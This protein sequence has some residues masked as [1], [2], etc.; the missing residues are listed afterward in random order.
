MYIME[1]LE[2]VHGV[3]CQDYKQGD[4][5]TSG[6][7][8]P[9]RKFI[10]SAMCRP[11]AAKWSP[12]AKNT[13][14]ET[15]ILNRVDVSISLWDDVNKTQGAYVIPYI[16]HRIMQTR[17]ASGGDGLL[18]AV[19]PIDNENTRNPFKNI[20]LSKELYDTMKQ[21]IENSTATFVQKVQNGESVSAP[22]SQVALGSE[23]MKA[24]LKVQAEFAARR[25]AAPQA[26][27]K[28]A[29]TSVA[30]S[31]AAALDDEN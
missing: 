15:N 10:I 12:S 1:N 5:T 6:V 18:F 4:V 20:L 16:S 23:L 27:T 19:N 30:Q 7:I 11:G 17:Q 8:S 29:E 25:T 21:A 14:V 9:D 22:S 13:N 28:K 24:A 3:K 2:V 31:A 26:A